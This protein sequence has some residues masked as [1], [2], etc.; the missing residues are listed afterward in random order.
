MLR[1]LRLL[2]PAL[3]IAALTFGAGLMQVAPLRAET[4]PS[5]GVEASAADANEPTDQD[6][7]AG[8][9]AVEPVAAP[10]PGAP[11]TWLTDLGLA[12]LR[13][14]AQ[15]APQTH[16]ISPLG[17]ATV[18]AMLAD[19]AQGETAEGLAQGLGL[20]AETA[21][22]TVAALWQ[23]MAA[24]GDG[25]ELLGAS[26]LWL[27]PDLQA[28]ADYIARQ[29]AALQAEVAMVDFADPAVLDQ[30][31]AW[32][33]E[34]TGGMIPRLLARLLPETRVVLGN[35][36]YLRARWQIG[37]D[38]DLTQPGVFRTAAGTETEVQ[39]MQRESQFLYREA[40][41]HQAVILPFADA[42]FVLTLY[43]PTEGTTPEALLAPGAALADPA[44]F[45]PIRGL[46]EVPRLDLEAG[47]DLAGVL[48]NLGMLSGANY[49]GLTAE[50]LELNVVIQKTALK[51][52]ET[53]AEAAAA[54]VALF[55]RGLAVESFHFR[56]DR[57][58]ALSIT[59]LPSATPLFLGV[60]DSL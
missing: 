22:A 57:P 15:G 2:H 27:A 5:T 13:D 48:V 18:L 12:V 43:L 16:L 40:A 49:A 35:A 26:G 58:F 44:G 20:P 28:R 53:G 1:R 41:D 42:D 51:L 30:L 8:A 9:T 21:L 59:H 60:I 33:S 52:D 34:R 36:L 3:V 55:T 45:H 17:L 7:V 6:S 25:V 11:E 10:D 50:P 29:Q 38:P 24:P 56:A 54:T 31:N 19:G 47:G 46:V 4:I 39:I 37:F 32:F 14:V 23:T